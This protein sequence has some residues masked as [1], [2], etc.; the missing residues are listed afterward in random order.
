MNS[1][2]PATTFCKTTRCPS[3]ETL[4]LYRRQTVSITDRIII[5]RHLRDCDFCNAE[6]QLL[7]RHQHD[8]EDPRTT[9]IPSKI[10]RLAETFFVKDRALA[11]TSKVV[12]YSG[13]LSH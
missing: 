13:P 5:Q 2:S 9:E 10:R 6:L 3:S 11:L 12:V 4:L 8:V 1:V 7:K